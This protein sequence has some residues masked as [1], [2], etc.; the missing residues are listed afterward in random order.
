MKKNIIQK[1]SN[2]N[3]SKLLALFTILIWATSYIGA[4][5]ALRKIDSTSLIVIRFFIQ[6]ILL[7]LL[8]F[9]KKM[10][11]PN[12]K[13]IPFFILSGLL[14][15]TFY[16]VAFNKG[17]ILVTTATSSVFI[18]CAPIFTALFSTIFLKEKINF[19]SWLSIGISFIGILILT[20]WEGVFTFNI[21]IFWMLS[22]ALCMSLYN[23]LQRRFTKKYTSSEASTY[24]MIAGSICIILYSPNSLLKLT[25][26]NIHL[27][28]LIFYLAAVV[29]VIAYFLWGKAFALSDTTSDV[30][31]FM[32]LSPFVV[33][34]IGIIFLN[35]K[36]TIPTVI[37]GFFIFLGIIGYNKFKYK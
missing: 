18:S 30:A 2:T 12:I 27:F 36:I 22:A 3:I 5:I 10:K 6:A 26:I 8:I 37:G 7:I 13:D 35:E 14:G 4:K 11:L 1:Y 34:I 33:T 15:F 16:M 9:I 28:L 24:S 25:N 23:V 17:I 21:G 19:Y 29:G 31:N 32:F 20:L